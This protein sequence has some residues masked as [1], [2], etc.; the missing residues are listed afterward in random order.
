MKVT[1]LKYT[2]EILIKNNITFI[3]HEKK[4][5]AFK[6]AYTLY[7]KENYWDGVYPVEDYLITSVEG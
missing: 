7:N 5:F 3:R 6:E 2:G 1:I 4:C